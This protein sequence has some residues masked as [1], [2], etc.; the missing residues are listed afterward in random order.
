MTIPQPARILH[1]TLHKKWFDA[2]ARGEKKEEYR[3]CK[4]YWDRRLKGLGF[5]IMIYFRNGYQ[6][7]APKMLVHCTGMRMAEFDGKKCY[8]LQLGQIDYIKNWKG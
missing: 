4:P 1:L 3:E 6:K 2:I 8:A 5:P 7:S